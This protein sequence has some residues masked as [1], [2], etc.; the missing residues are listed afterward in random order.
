MS[1]RVHSKTGLFFVIILLVVVSLPS[2][3]FGH[4]FGA[5]SPVVNAGGDKTLRSGVYD[6][7][8]EGSASDD[9]DHG[10]TMSWSKTSGPGSVI[11]GNP[12][13]PRTS[14]Y[15]SEPGTYVLTL[16]AD[17]GEHENSDSVT[18]TVKPYNKAPW[19]KRVL[20]SKRTIQLPNDSVV[21]DV[22]VTDDGNP[23]PPGELEYTWS[24]AAAF[25][26]PLSKRTVATFTREGTYVLTCTVSDGERSASKSVTVIVNPDPYPNP[27]ARL[28]GD[29][30]AD[31][32]DLEK[33]TDDSEKETPDK[34]D[35]SSEKADP[36]YLKTGEYY[37][38]TRDLLVSGW[39]LDIAIE[40]QYRS[41][42]EYNSCFG[43]GW[44][45]SYNM[46]IR[47]LSSD[48]DT[49]IFLNGKNGRTEYV[50]DV[51]NPDI[52]T[53]P[54]DTGNYFYY[55]SQTETFTYVKKYGTELDFDIN[56]NLSAIGDRN[57]NSITFEYDPN[58]LLPIYGTSKFF[59]EEELG[60]PSNGRD[61]VAMAYKL[62]KI[63]DDMGREIELS[64]NDE[65]LLETVTDFAGRTWKYTYD[66]VTN[67][68]CSVTKPATEHYPFGRTIMYSYDNNHNLTSI[69]DPSSNTWLTNTYYGDDERVVSQEYGDGIFYLS[70]DPDSNEA[71]VTDRMDFETKTIFDDE[72]QIISD[73][74][75]TV[76][77]RPNEPNFY[78]ISY[79]HD[80]T[81]GQRTKKVS[82]EGNWIDYTY[83]PNGNVLTITREPND[84]E[85]N[86]V[87][88]YTYDPKFNFVETITNPLNN[89]VIYD[90]N[91]IN[92][93]L[94]TVT[95]PVVLTP[96]GDQAPVVSFT[97]NS[98]GQIETVTDPNEIITKCLYYDDPCDVNNYSQ[99][100]KVIVDY[101]QTDA[102]A[103]NITSEYKYDVLGNVIEVNDPNGDITKFAYN[104]LNKLTKITSPSP[105]NYIT[106]F[107]YNQNNLLSM[108]E[109]EIS[110]P[111]QLVEYTY[112][113]LD[114][115]EK[116]TDTL[117]NTTAFYYDKSENFSE[118]KDAE[119]NS[120]K[121][122]YDE[123]NLLW[124]VTDANGDVTEF[125]YTPNDKLAE[126]NDANNN[127]T[128]YAYDG[129]DRLTKITY[130]DDSNEV[131]GYDAA[132]NVTSWKSRNNETIY[133]EYD[134][135]NRL[136]VKNRPGE[137]NI[138]FLYGI[139]G[140]IVEVNDRG[141]L[142]QYT[143]DRIGRVV[144]VNN[145]EGRLVSYEY[146]ER[147]LRTKLIY[148]DSSFITYEY[149]AMSRLT[150]IIDD[151]NTVLAEYEY[152][153]LSR[154][155]LLTLANDANAVYEYDLV[156]RLT[157][158]TN[159]YSDTNSLSFY[160]NSYDNVGNRLSMLVDDTDEHSYDYDCLYQLKEV[161]Y[162]DDEM[163]TYYYDSLGN[164][165]QTVNGS[166]TNYSSNNLNQYTAVGG[167]SYSYDN[168][169]N[170]T[171]DGTYKYYYD[172]ENRLTDVNNQSDEPLASYK[173][174]YL[175]RRVSKT[176]Y[177]TLKTQNYVYDGA[178]VIAEYD[179]N[180]VLLRRYF[181]GVGIDEPLAMYVAGS[182]YYY[183]HFDGLGSVVAL[184]NTDGEVVEFYEYD[185]FGAPTIWDVNTMD[186]VEESTIGNPYL[187]TGRRFDDETGNYYYRARYYSPEIGRFLQTD[188]IYYADGLN[189]YS[190]CNNNPVNWIDPWGLCKEDGSDETED[191]LVRIIWE[192]IKAAMPGGWTGDAG[193]AGLEGGTSISAYKAVLEAGLQDPDFIG[194]ENYEKLREIA[195]IPAKKV[196]PKSPK[197]K[198]GGD[199]SKARKRR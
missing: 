28:P 127:V 35:D 163:V 132:S 194:S 88:A 118:L 129:F 44:D 94:E 47:Q 62:V 45:M 74:T 187:F 16:N 195:Q 170:L 167:V 78:R 119:E 141:D 165:M 117:F 29:D 61:I 158:L 168:N 60:G 126:I 50:S 87:V 6:T 115:I 106:N 82:P 9:G 108:V 120:T 179:G 39:A 5:Q 110:G 15:F 183:Y 64:Y 73:T 100:W 71:T 27:D 140:Q 137:P 69:Q 182:G 84:S 92:G 178:Q 192:A 159:H 193:R 113:I 139:A 33:D 57:G 18:I 34:K 154:R 152:D 196:K 52:Y 1:S 97:Y 12:S 26:N 24:G 138:T 136:I 99:L 75:Y 181:Y 95:Y 96:D 169:G 90:Y 109:K 85:P 2:L 53:N 111:N 77:L 172:C 145:P 3:M 144:D 188:P 150:K 156:D 80:D 86:I 17:D 114:N 148:P 48:P 176:Q 25:G 128:S 121:Y 104:N 31:P 36:I 197:P 112:D 42:S 166:T 30:G 32:N 11:F 4:T 151:S 7:A 157:Q 101:N 102:N 105:Y 55:D 46:K 98:Y 134:A 83:D 142:T 190:Y 175:G 93:N 125:S 171:N 122:E 191:G 51:G 49:I 58:G 14:V 38:H 43:Y 116:S 20:R 199:G 76:G 72:G 79:E 147:G 103:L 180:D 41:K 146:D 68:L 66:R 174:D 10:L 189:W 124:K 153:Q 54:I 131:F 81:S 123:R 70:Y 40:R 67:D 162:P 173:Y 135:L 160:Y 23:D 198:S 22:S 8:S 177:L 13:Q 155:T 91:D 19:I 186:I 21:V 89:V 65:G 130:P 133:Y 184:S 143:Y 149:D 37:F 161:N 164:R 185:V 63:T 59:L 56:G 107:S